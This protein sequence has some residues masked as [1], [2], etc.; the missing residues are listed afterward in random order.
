MQNRRAF[1]RSPSNSK[2][3]M[4]WLVCLFLL[5]H[6]NIALAAEATTDLRV[7]VDISGSMKKTDP[8]NLRRPA[9]RLLAG[10]V[11]SGS[12][13]GIWNFGKQVNM[14]VKIGDVDE[15]W[16]KLAR[17]QSK[18]ISSVG[19]YTN[20]ESAMRKA[21]FDW[22]K[23]D[24]KYKRNLILLTDGH[25]DISK[26]ENEDKA[27]RKRIIKDILPMLEK[28]KVRVHTIALSDDVDESL[29]STLSAY[30]D[31]LYKKVKNADDLQKVFLQMLEQSVALDTLPLKNNRFNVD[32]NINDM[33]M[34]VFNKDKQQPTKIVT[35]AKKTWDKNTKDENINWFSDQGFDLITIKKPQRGEWKI[36]APVDP[37][38]RVVV[39][40]NLKLK[41]AP[42]PGYMM[43][44]DSLKVVA[45]L[46]ED[47]KPLSDQRLLSRFKFEL[48]KKVDNSAAT[49]H[50][51]T[52]SAANKL[53]Y[54]V[55]LPPVFQAGNIELVVQA[56]SPTAQRES[57]H[58]VKVYA[59]P[60]EIS[61]KKIDGKYQVNVKP[62]SNLLR[63]G[64]VKL[65]A[66]LKDNSR[67]ELKQ[68]G[69]SW[70]LDVDEQFHQSMFD[71][72]VEAVRA[73]GK[74]LAMNFSKVLAEQ[75]EKQKLEPVQK[76]ETKSAGSNKQQE[77]KNKNVAEGKEKDKKL[78]PETESTD[79][80]E[81]EINWTLVII[82]IVVGN[83]VLI[84]SAAAAYYYMKCRKRKM[85]EELGNEI[86]MSNEKYGNK[87]S[88]ETTEQDIKEDKGDKKPDE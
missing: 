54:E 35:P 82:S 2:Q 41:L 12:R 15:N 59:A 10:L 29:L 45:S 60:A 73:D 31:G 25:V 68:Q 24:P 56:K 66:T 84:S 61:I 78:K 65:V 37:A 26:D 81:Q 8:R 47:N 80:K 22:K 88:D 62:Y 23:P 70:V 76:A 32:A 72:S 74:P 85:A 11:P 39:A 19:L 30:T 71:L 64:S 46:H 87:E 14:A 86:A 57:R 34:L 21:S 4:I 13:A 18:K 9:I 7:I 38:N 53:N 50:A 51:M 1:L 17:E 55:Q 42:L 33:T 27:S 20:I 48:N 69:D 63:P 58:Q 40:T 6:F 5:L 3:L 75:G 36:V 44:G 83:I 52:S 49:S 16:R 79:K 28:A 43:M 77:I 67:H